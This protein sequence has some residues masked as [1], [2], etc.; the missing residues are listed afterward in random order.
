MNEMEYKIQTVIN[1]LEDIDI[2]ASFNNM[3]RMMGALQVLADI[4]DQFKKAPEIKMEAVQDGDAD[5][6]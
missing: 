3:N 4:R 5:A 1:T 6:E 2:K